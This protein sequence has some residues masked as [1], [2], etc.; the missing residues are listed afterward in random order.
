M[1]KLVTLEDLVRVPPERFGNPLEETV[2]DILKTGYDFKGRLEGG[3]EGKLD[4][5][6]GMVLLIKDIKGVEEGSLIPGDGGAYHHVTF[7]A[8]TYKPEL[9]EIVDA[10]VLEIVEFGAFIRF[11]PLDGLIHV[12]QVTDDYITY[13]EKNGALR[14][15]ET[16]RLLQAGDKVRARIVA[17][18]LNPDKSKE[19]KINLTMRQPGLG[20]FEWLEEDKKKPKKKK[21][22]KK[23]AKK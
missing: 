18:S 14:G 5:D 20:K 13:D 10:E 6:L 12:S 3:Y 11:G 22:A 1:F 17:I 19:S 4:K 7:E 8:L 15:K 23:E 9:H 21:K 16:G 2:K